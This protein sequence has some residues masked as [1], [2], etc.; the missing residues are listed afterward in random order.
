MCFAIDLM[1]LLLLCKAR[2]LNREVSCLTLRFV[3]YHSI[4]CLPSQSLSPGVIKTGALDDL[5]IKDTC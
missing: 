5:R 2:N 1:L 3:L 4:V